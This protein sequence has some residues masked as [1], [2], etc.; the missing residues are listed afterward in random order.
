MQRFRWLASCLLTIAT[1]GSLLAITAGE[2]RQGLLDQIAGY[3]KWTRVTPEIL[4]K[5]DISDGAVSPA[6]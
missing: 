3:R 5:I 4:K 1:I 2:S 6:G